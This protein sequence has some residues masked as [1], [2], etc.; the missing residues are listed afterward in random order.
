M[1]SSYERTLPDFDQYLNRFTP[2]AQIETDD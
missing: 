2:A 1:S